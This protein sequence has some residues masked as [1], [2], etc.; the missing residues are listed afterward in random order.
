MLGRRF[1]RLEHRGRTTGLARQTVLEVVDEI[2]ESPVIV[3]GFGES[4]DWL[5]NVRAES[6]V[7]VVWGRESFP[8][9]AR[10]LGEEEAIAALA[11]YRIAHPRAAE[12]LGNSLGVS[13][14]DDLRTTVRKLPVLVLDRRA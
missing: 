3:S 11:R 12:V 1:L 13:L 9:D 6:R 4:S 5:K 10:P 8:A 2:D 14:V 7:G